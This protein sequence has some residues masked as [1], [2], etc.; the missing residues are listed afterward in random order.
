[1][2]TKIFLLFFFMSLFVFSQERAYKLGDEVEYFD[3]INWVESKVLQVSPGKCLVYLNNNMSQ[4]K[5]F[6]NSDIQLLFP[7]KPFE[8]EKVE[9]QKVILTAKYKVGDLVF[10]NSN[11]KIISSEI[12]NINSNN[13][14]YLVYIDENKSVVKWLEEKELSQQGTTKTET[15]ITKEVSTSNQIIIYTIGN[16][17]LI[18]VG[19]DWIE[20]EIIDIRDGKFQVFSD[21]EKTLT[22]WVEPSEI[23][24]L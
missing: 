4:T 2:K 6:D 1:M 22:K 24:R 10:F 8:M 14:T 12:I 20:S 17:I 18:K 13:F 11:G 7:D 5:W 19:N 9:T 21:K 15:V 16:K 23:K 3:G